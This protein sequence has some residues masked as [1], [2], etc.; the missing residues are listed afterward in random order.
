MFKLKRK[1]FVITVVFAVIIGLLFMSLMLIGKISSYD[2]NRIYNLRKVD[3]TYRVKLLEA[4]IDRVYKKN[5]I[6]ILGD[7]QPNGHNFPNEYIFSTL[8]EKKLQQN[9][10]NMAFQ[11]SRILDNLYILDYCKNKNYKFEKVIFNINQS[12]IKQSSFQHL[13]VLNKMDYKLKIFKDLKSFFK[14][15]FVPNPVS[16]PSENLKLTKYENYF[17]MN[18][19]SINLYLNKVEKLINESKKVTNELIIYLT[20]HSTNAIQFNDENDLEKINQFN[21]LVY[22]KC[23]KKLITCFEPKIFDDKYY[24]DIVHFNS[25]GHQKM[26]EELFELLK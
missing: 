26:S 5:S 7:S 16:L 8:L 14:I 9:I 18:N 23:E 12:H 4:Y 2:E 21:K 11:D 22:N 13:D 19:T 24:I 1:T 15:A 3:K 17:D 25:L 6:L 10:I 20:P